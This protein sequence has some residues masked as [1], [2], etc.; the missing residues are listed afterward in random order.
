MQ[1]LGFRKHT[2]FRKYSER[3]MTMLEE[4]GDIQVSMK[5]QI[6]CV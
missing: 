3:G 2:T 5:T 4:E 1:V 6:G